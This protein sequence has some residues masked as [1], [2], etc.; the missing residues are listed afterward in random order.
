MTTAIDR[1]KSRIDELDDAIDTIPPFSQEERKQRRLLNFEQQKML[2]AKNALQTERRERKAA[3]TGIPR[4]TA[5]EAAE[6]RAAVTALNR[7]IKADQSFDVIVAAARG[8]NAAAERIN[9]VS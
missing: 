1:L 7:V 4:L 3:A 8:I 9:N 2:A 6:F 5:R